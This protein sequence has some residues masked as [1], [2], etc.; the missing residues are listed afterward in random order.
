MTPGVLLATSAGGLV[1]SLT[2][3]LRAAR[4]WLATS[5]V[6]TLAALAAAVWVLATGVAWEWRSA[7]LIGGE[8]VHLRLDGVSALFLALLAVVGG[9]GAAYSREYWARPGA[10]RLALSWAAAGGAPCSCAWDLS[11]CARTDCISSSPGSCSP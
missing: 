11:C 7:F 8:G 3:A 1:L 6:S 10:P 4:W 9:A 2:G 5:L